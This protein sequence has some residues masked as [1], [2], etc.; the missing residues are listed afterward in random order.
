MG[1]EPER[2]RVIRADTLNAT[3][4]ES[5][6]LTHSFM[7]SIQESWKWLA[8]MENEKVKLASLNARGCFTAKLSQHCQNVVITLSRRNN[9]SS[10]TF[11]SDYI[12]IQR[13]F[14]C[15]IL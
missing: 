2:L 15:E 1:D 10:R 6:A 8:T 11:R 9:D 7:S 14:D 13:D 3:N 4:A 5:C 12:V